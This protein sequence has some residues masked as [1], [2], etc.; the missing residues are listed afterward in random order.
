M[1]MR[2]I[3]F[4]LVVGASM[5]TIFFKKLHKKKSGFV[6]SGQGPYAISP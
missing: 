6:K 3:I 1:V 2:S 5:Y 4:S